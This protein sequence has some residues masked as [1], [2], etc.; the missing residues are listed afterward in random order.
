MEAE[1]Q[2]NLPNKIGSY[3]I[4]ERIASGGMGEVFLAFDPLCKRKIALKKIRSDLMEHPTLKERFLREAKI[5]AQLSHPC[6]IPIYGIHQDA[7]EVY[8]T[9][10]F[11]EGETLKAVLKQT[12]DLEK[13]GTQQHP[14]GSSI[15]VL[16]RIF[17]NIC[18]AIAYSHAKGILHRDL[19]PENIIIGKYG[20]VLILDWGL[21]DCIDLKERIPFVDIQV[22]DETD[23][24]RPGK[25]AGTL[26][27]LSP[28]R[29][30]GAP[31]SVSSDIYSLGVILYQ[32]LTLHFP[33]YRKSAKGYRK[34]MKHER[35]IDPAER[36]PY[37]DIPPQLTK[38]V[39]K[40]LSPQKEKRYLSL[41]DLLLDLQNYLE[42]H[43][44]WIPSASICVHH[45]QDWEFQEN[46]LL[47]QHLALT[48]ETDLM[49]WVNLMISKD[50]FPG[51]MKL[52]THVRVKESSQG[53]GFL[54]NIK[55]SSERKDL[56]QDGFFLWIGSQQQPGSH[57]FRSNAE[58]MANPEISLQ[59]LLS[60]CIRL[61]KTE[62]HLLCYLDNTLIFDYLS[63]I[64]LHGPHFGILL[65]DGDLDV[66]TILVSSSS[67]RMSVSCLAV[68]DAFLSH[69]DFDLALT[70]YRMI[71]HSFPGRAEGREAIFRA[72]ITLL[73]KASTRPTIKS[74]LLEQ[75]LEEFSKLRNTPSAPLEY[76]G[77][78]LVYKAT[79][80]IEEET[81]C[82]ELAIRKHPKHPL[83]SLLKDEVVFRLYEAAYKNRMAAY[84]FVLLA[85][86][87][88]PERLSKPDH[89]KL[90]QSLEKNRE[91]LWFIEPCPNHIAQLCIELAFWL[92]KPQALIEMAHQSSCQTEIANILFCLATLGSPIEEHLFLLQDSAER[93]CFEAILSEKTIG[94]LETLDRYFSSSD[95]FHSFPVKRAFFYLLDTAILNNTK[96]LFLSRLETIANQEMPLSDW[97]AFQQ[98]YIWLLLLHDTK[99]LA[100]YQLNKVL[101]KIP[102]E[103]T[104]PFYFLQ[105]CLVITKEGKEVACSLLSR[106][107]ELAFPQTVFLIDAYLHE[108]ISLRSGWGTQ[109]FFWEKIELLKQLALYSHCAK[110]QMD[111]KKHLK[112]IIR[113]YQKIHEHP[114]P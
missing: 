30:L 82:L 89:Q 27:Y 34:Q 39:K 109:A 91:P 110:L 8:Y 24:T 47:A 90:L 41:D 21:A 16:M 75:A 80:E 86:R 40:S 49:E 23:L 70:E 83:I 42:G 38:I 65:K 56:F 73:E 59:P 33:F 102:L 22:D 17:L 25:V 20:E 58:L 50:P 15:P 6:I 35:L 18:Q 45:K 14:I 61:E 69:R 26:A 60:H 113:K 88:L 57:L 95:F 93:L 37:R 1:N 2:T 7:E 44:E 105:S 63:H 53:I 55:P 96:P 68:P 107:R 31:A 106:N 32:M 98:R 97:L 92:A 108:K 78:S 48:Q 3:E 66:G 94:F 5:A 87:H 9:M 71:S 4:L 111:Y 79:H 76:L 100:E 62:N 46:I 36:S 67:P 101:N 11:A 12:A 52:E 54:L 29:I 112:Q 64:P 104:S 72:G 85:L 99:D 10:P 103:E 43:A 81:K 74:S 77:K 51:N 19:K 84:H 13:E 28:E 114:H